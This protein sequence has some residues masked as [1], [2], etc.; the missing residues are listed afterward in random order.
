MGKWSNKEFALAFSFPWCSTAEG[1][2]YV[3]PPIFDL[4]GKKKLA[5]EL[6]SMSRRYESFCEI[7]L[8]FRYENIK[9]IRLHRKVAKVIIVS[10]TPSSLQQSGFIV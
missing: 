10:N 5:G 6:K 8:N 3:F 9:R 4:L 1:S 7:P 2:P